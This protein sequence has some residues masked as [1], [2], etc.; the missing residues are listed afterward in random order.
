MYK[1]VVLNIKKN[2]LVFLVHFFKLGQGHHKF[3]KLVNKSMM[4]VKYKKYFF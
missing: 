3:N 4:Q 2:K 1:F